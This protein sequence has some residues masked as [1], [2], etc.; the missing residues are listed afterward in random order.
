MQR[1][2]LSS[3]SL[4]LSKTIKIS[5]VCKPGAANCV[6]QL[7]S[8]ASIK[9]TVLW[10]T[11]KSKYLRS[12]VVYLLLLEIAATTTPAE[13]S[14]HAHSKNLRVTLFVVTLSLI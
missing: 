2:R 3:V 6:I 11:V 1:K 14:A 13:R 8:E 10:T 5:I 7:P 4:L 9:P 12:R